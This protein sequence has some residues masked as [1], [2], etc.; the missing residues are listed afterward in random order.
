MPQLRVSIG[1]FKPTD[2]SKILPGMRNRAQVATM[3]FS[4]ATENTDAAHA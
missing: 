1:L 3:L 2:T 4:F